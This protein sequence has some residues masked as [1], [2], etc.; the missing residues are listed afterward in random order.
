MGFFTKDIK[1]LNDLFVHTLHDIYYA[2]Q[3]IAKN[4]PDMISKAT[5][6]SL[7]TGFETHLAETKNQISRLEKSLPNAW[8]QGEG[9]RLPRHRRHPGRSKRGCRRS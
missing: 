2:E 5:E 6:Q 4:L 1:T 9:C 3:Q 8:R 7:K